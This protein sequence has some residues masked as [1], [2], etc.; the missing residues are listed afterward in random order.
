M[1]KVIVAYVPVLHEGY[2]AFFDRHKDASALYILGRDITSLHRPLVKDIRALDPELMEKAIETLGIFSKVEIGGAEG[3]RALAAED[4]SIVMPQEDISELIAKEFFGGKSITFDTVFLRW[5]HSK[6]LSRRE[7]VPDETISKDKFA[8]E[9]LKNLDQAAQVGSDFFRRVGAAVVKD[10]KVVLS[11]RNRHLPTEHAPYESGDPRGNFSSGDHI[12]FSTSIHA[13]AELIA[14]AAREGISIKG[15]DMYA[16][17]FPCP[18]CSKLIAE[19]GVRRLFFAGGYSV[20]DGE[21]V[22]HAKGIEIIRV[23]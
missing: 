4:V 21:Q 8:Q 15:M 7:L 9:L 13:E 19:S 6:S 20:L 22:M 10:G 23:E 1:E 18:P 14:Q 2:R 3:L 16:T 5:D 17:V 12:E 11:S